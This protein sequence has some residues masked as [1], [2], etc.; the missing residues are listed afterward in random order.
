M[1]SAYI[2]GA[3]VGMLAASFLYYQFRLKEK[4]PSNV[5]IFLIENMGIVFGGALFGVAVIV[6]L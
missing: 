4:I 2:C 3:V 1:N 6:A 5:Y